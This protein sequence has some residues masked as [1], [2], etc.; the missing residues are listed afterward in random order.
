[1]AKQR[2]VMAK[3]P[4]FR[5]W[6]PVTTLRRFLDMRRD[7]DNQ[8][9][10]LEAKEDELAECEGQVTKLE[11]H[12]QT[13]TTERNEAREACKGWEESGHK[14][15]AAGDRLLT[16]LGK[17]RME[18]NQSQQAEE[19]MAKKNKKL[20]KKTKKLEEAVEDLKQIRDSYHQ[21]LEDAVAA[22]KEATALVEKQRE[23]LAQERQVIQEYVAQEKARPIVEV[24]V[25]TKSKG[26]KSR[27][28]WK[29]G[30]TLES[31]KEKTLAVCLPGG[32]KNM[33]DLR[34]ALHILNVGKWVVKNPKGEGD[35]S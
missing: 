16:E 18:R 15:R 10:M 13:V 19:E 23:E 28:Y 4:P 12:I 11:A 25:H 33:D 1:M 34:Q 21:R 3:D 6:W 7:R 22:G 17:M 31:G 29:A 8:L 27:G 20:K 2:E 32:Y 9:A 14:R 5:W 26:K 30:I 24:D 35:A